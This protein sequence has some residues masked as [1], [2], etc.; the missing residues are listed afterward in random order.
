MYIRTI[1][2]YKMFPEDDNNDN[3]NDNDDGDTLT[4]FWNI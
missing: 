3:N 2:L 4:E 1:I